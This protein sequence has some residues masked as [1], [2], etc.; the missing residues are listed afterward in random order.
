VAAT[1]CHLM[2]YQAGEP[3]LDVPFSMLMTLN[4]AQAGPLSAVLSRKQLSPTVVM[5]LHLLNEKHNASSAFQPWLSVLPTTFETPLSWTEDEMAALNGS[6]VTSVVRRRKEAMR[7]DYD[8][9]FGA[10]FADFP[11]LFPREQYTFEAFSWALCTV[12]SRAFVFNIQSQLVPVIVPYADLL[13]H[14][15]GE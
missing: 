2:S 7:S 15:N 5:A 11:A 12:W 14:G 3:V 13:E 9:L 1:Y 8:S 6:T 4:T 10:L